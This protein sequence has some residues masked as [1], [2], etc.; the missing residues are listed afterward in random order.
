MTAMLWGISGF[1]GIAAVFLLSITIPFA[2]RRERAARALSLAVITAVITAV[3][4]TS[5]D[6][7]WGSALAWGM[8]AAA[9]YSSQQRM[10]HR[11]AQKIWMR[12]RL[13]I[14]RW[15]A[16]T[17]LRWLEWFSASD[18]LV[19]HIAISSRSDVLHGLM[20][21]LHITTAQ[22][23]RIQ[24]VLEFDD[25]AITSFARPLQTTKTVRIT[26]TI[27]PLLLDELHR[28]KQPTYVVLDE[29]DEVVGTIRHD[30]IMNASQHTSDIASLT[31][32]HLL[33]VSPH[34][35]ID[36]VIECMLSDAIWLA[37]IDDGEN[38]QVIMLHDILG[39]LLGKQG[40]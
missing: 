4:I 13:Q 34:T 6:A 17:Q 5:Y 36:E 8:A 28:A 9:L 35:G 38:V 32:P 14:H 29:N 19:E 22:K 21:S 33:R 7:L 18:G 39:Y 24:A 3:S 25:M 37:L 2:W 23:H 26:D 27:G 31:Q 11:L 10:I 30:V 1:L 20:D 16:V 40:R 15:C 12:Y